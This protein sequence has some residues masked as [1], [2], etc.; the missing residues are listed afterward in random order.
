MARRPPYAKYANGNANLPERGPGKF[1][2]LMENVFN[3]LQVFK[4]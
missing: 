3:K 1:Y 4:I 2:Y